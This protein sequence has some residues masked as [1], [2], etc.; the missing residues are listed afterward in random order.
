MNYFYEIRDWVL[1]SSVFFFVKL[2]SELSVKKK[3]K[4]QLYVTKQSL[5]FGF[6]FD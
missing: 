4:L 2:T 1:I 6:E 5:L 3:H